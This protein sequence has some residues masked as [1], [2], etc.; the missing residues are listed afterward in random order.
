MKAPST[1]DQSEVKRSAR[2]ESLQDVYRRAMA[3]HV[4]QLRVVV[5]RRMAR[6]ASK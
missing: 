3:R 5:G 4:K 6:A 1:Q 2:V